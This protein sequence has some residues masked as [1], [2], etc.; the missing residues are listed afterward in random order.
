MSKKIDKK[1]LVSC[2]GHGI[3]PKGHAVGFVMGPTLEAAQKRL[4]KGAGLSDKQLSSFDY[5]EVPVDET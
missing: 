3:M 2:G 1:W 4:Q 5:T